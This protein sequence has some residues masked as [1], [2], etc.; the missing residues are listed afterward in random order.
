MGERAFRV[1]SHAVTAISSLDAFLDSPAHRD[2]TRVVRH[3]LFAGRGL[4]LVF[5]D[6]DAAAELVALLTRTH[7]A[8]G[9]HAL[10]IESNPPR[11]TSSASSEARLVPDASV[12]QLVRSA[13]RQDPDVIAVDRVSADEGSLLFNTL[14]TGHQVLAGSRVDS[15]DAFVD[16]L[17]AGEPALRVHA[18]EAVD[19]AIEV[20]RDAQGRPR[21]V[22]VQR[23]AE[24]TWVDVV[25]VEN[26]ACNVS[27]ARL[28]AVSPPEPIFPPRADAAPPMRRPAVASPRPAFLPRV[29]ANAEG[30]HR[31][32]SRRVLRSAGAG[33][34]SCR[35]CQ[36]PLAH[37]VQLDLSAIPEPLARAPALAQLFVCTHGCESSNE[38]APGVVVELLPLEGLVEVDAPGDTG[39]EAQ[40]SGVI[41]DFARVYE[42]PEQDDVEEDDEDAPRPLRCDKV[43]GWPAW[44]QGPEWP[45]GAGWELLFQLVEGPPLA[46]GTRDGWDFDAAE[47]VRGTPPAPVLE[48]HTPRHFVSLLTRE[49]SAF[50]FRSADSTRLAFRWQTG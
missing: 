38:A 20:R 49:A 24:S 5:G 30:R 8:R 36:A 35:S 6:A 12:A 41:V 22:R 15:P 28:P 37:V 1:R 25:R 27:R 32:A 26:G 44:E 19:Q 18:V 7:P 9:I 29:T 4:T 23:R 13:L 40:S 21:I 50:L 3:G 14:T 45:D 48:A 43:G 10:L 42:E 11:I 2:V 16:L 47:L 31:L 33:W 34:P 17:V 46:G 39:A